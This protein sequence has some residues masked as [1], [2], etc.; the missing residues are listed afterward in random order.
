MTT[1]QIANIKADQRCTL[2]GR[3]ED[4]QERSTQSGQPMFLFTL[5]DN[6]GS[7]KCRGFSEAMDKHYKNI[8]PGESYSLRDVKMD[9]RNGV[10]EI[11]IWSETEINK[12]VPVSID[13]TMYSTSAV[14]N[15]AEVG[16]L[17]NVRGVAHGM[18]PK[19]SMKNGQEKVSAYL[20][21]K[22]GEIPIVFTGKVLE[23]LPDDESVVEL[24]GRVSEQRHLFVTMRPTKVEDD[25]DLLS[26][27]RDNP[28]AKK[29]KV[30]CK[31]ADLKDMTFGASVAMKGVVTEVGHP[32]ETSNGHTKKNIHIVDSSG[33]S[34]LVSAF[35]EA[36]RKG[37]DT[38]DVIAFNGTVS[39][40]N[41]ISLRTNDFDVVRD[42]DLELWWKKNGDAPHTS[43]SFKIEKEDASQM[44]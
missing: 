20:T 42:E 23:F 38:T 10:S 40:F 18:G 27:Y 26:W 15:E 3:V 36:S 31:I 30:E 5:V 14:A 29:Q 7:I 1:T 24:R 39:S 12:S 43:I 34:V 19:T 9:T 35:E 37:V 11:K 33:H 21:D 28:P 17:V 16:S 32:F 22:Q 44:S 6:T 41:T 4:M 2:R 8:I 13:P 25:T